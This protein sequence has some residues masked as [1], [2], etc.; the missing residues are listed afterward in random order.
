MKLRAVAA[1]SATV[2]AATKTETTARRKNRCTTNRVRVVGV[3]WLMGTGLMDDG[4]GPG[5]YFVAA[6]VA[7]GRFVRK[8]STSSIVRGTDPDRRRSPVSSSR[9]GPSV[10]RPAAAYLRTAACAR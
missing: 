4:C 6:L 7:A 10:R 2:A 3:R 5:V 1:V 8:L 9:N